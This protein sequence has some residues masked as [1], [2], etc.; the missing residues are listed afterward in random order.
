VE[1]LFERP[2]AEEDAIEEVDVLVTRY[3]EGSA[4]L[5]ALQLHKTI[6]TLAWLFHVEY[7]G[8]VRLA[9]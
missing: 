4:Y 5:R 8:V 7:S 3:R 6:G 2:S 1:P 9:Y